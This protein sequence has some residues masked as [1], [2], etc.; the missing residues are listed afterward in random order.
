MCTHS[1]KSI[2]CFLEEKYKRFFKCWRRRDRKIFDYVTNKINKN[3]LKQRIRYR[4]PKHETIDHLENVFVFDSETHNDQEFA[5]AYAAGLYDVNRL[6]DKWNTDIAPDERVIEKKKLSFL[7]II[8]ETLSR[9]CLNIIQ[10]FTK[11]M[12][13]LILMKTVM[14]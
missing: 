5:E 2:L 1:Q 4:F 14:R 3:N 6:R 7:I 8:M 11:V 12:R 10:K 9:S 13:K